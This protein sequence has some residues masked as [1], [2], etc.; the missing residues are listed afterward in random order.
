M[1]IDATNA[2]VGRL[3]S[4]VAKKALLGEEIIIVNAEKAVIR[5]DP[6]VVFEKYY[7]LTKKGNP[8]KGPF[9]S[10]RPDLLLRR[11]I[12]GMLPIKKPRGRE[13]FKRIKCYIG[14]P[15]Q[16]SNEKKEIIKEAVLDDSKYPKYI[17]ILELSKRLGWK[18]K[19]EI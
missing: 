7:S 13:A 8:F 18:P 11:M 14:V 12:R 4:V 19:V 1:I 16:Y 6:D 10:R 15:E 17:T 2:V 5:G 9:I 3:A